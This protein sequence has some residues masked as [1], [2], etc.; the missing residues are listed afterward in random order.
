M[1]L[2]KEFER[3]IKKFKTIVG[4]R[5]DHLDSHKHSHMRK[6]LKPIFEEYSKKHN[7]PVRAYDEV[8]FVQ[9]FFG[10]NKL[11]LKDHKRITADSL[12]K[13]LSNLQE[14]VNEIMCHPGIVDEE[15]K[16][17]SVYAK[18]RGIELETLMD[19]KV[20]DYITKSDIKLCN[21]NSI[22]R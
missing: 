2:T 21:W 13:I 6:R 19:K 11:L 3:Q 12:I 14:G 15:L 4:R 17:T 7:T 22:N 10:W 9:S 8:N 18:E 5:P 20:I 16:K 1:K